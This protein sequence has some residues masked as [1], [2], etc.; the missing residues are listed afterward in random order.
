MGSDEP[1]VA[2]SN[3]LVEVGSDELAADN[4]ALEVGSNGLLVAFWAGGDTPVVDCNDGS[5]VRSERSIQPDVLGLQTF[6][7]FVHLPWL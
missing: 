5:V 7:N 3:A 4:G 2:D 6:H 1:A